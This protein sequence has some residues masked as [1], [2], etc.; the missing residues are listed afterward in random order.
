MVILRIID[1]ENNIEKEYYPHSF[2]Q[3]ESEIIIK[4][5]NDN[6]EEITIKIPISEKDNIEWIP[7][8]II[9]TRSE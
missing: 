5:W 2:S 8:T 9:L 3:Y 7:E 1:H 4:Q 6:E